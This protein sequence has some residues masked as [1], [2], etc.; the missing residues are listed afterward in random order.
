[1]M[2]SQT[3]RR[4]A[5]SDLRHPAE[6]KLCLIFVVMESLDYLL[7]EFSTLICVLSVSFNRVTESG[8]AE[9]KPD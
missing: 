5:P 3:C 8:E 4:E 1:M 9:N 7:V 6:V 2:R